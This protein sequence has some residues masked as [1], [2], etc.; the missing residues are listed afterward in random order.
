MLEGTGRSCAQFDVVLEYQY[1]YVLYVC[2]TFH[3][4][5]F[6]LRVY[7]YTYTNGLFDQ[8]SSYC[9]PIDR[10]LYCVHLLSIGINRCGSA[11]GT[12]AAAFG[13]DSFVRESEADCV[14]TRIVHA[15]VL[16]AL[17][18]ADTEA[19]AALPARL[20]AALARRLVQLASSVHP[21][22]RALAAK[23]VCD[24]TRFF[25]LWPLQ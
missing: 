7:E 5:F 10:A 4:L 22:N 12:R 1:P 25:K 23:R 3:V 24:S 20:R 8:I 11:T 9:I 16:G 13:G 6:I 14:R 15:L 19:P 17:A 18:A 2:S 21:S